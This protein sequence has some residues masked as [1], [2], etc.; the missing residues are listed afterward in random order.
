VASGVL[1][2][3]RFGKVRAFTFEQNLRCITRK[4]TFGL[5]MGAKRRL[6]A[7]EV[8]YLGAYFE[9]QFTLHCAQADFWFT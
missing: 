9:Q 5:L 8:L 1:C 3:E 2:A 7:I 6:L 4:P